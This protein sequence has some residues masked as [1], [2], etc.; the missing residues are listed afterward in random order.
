[1]V[2]KLTDINRLMD[3][4]RTNLPGSLDGPIQLEFF[5]VLNDF[6][7]KSNLWV[8]DITFP[9][10]ASNVQ[11]STVGIASGDGGAINR[12]MYV[13][14]ADNSHRRMTM[15][16]PGALLFV[17]VPNAAATWT[18]RVSL[19]VIDPIPETG[20]L[21]GFPQAPDWILRKYNNGLLSGLLG[22]MMAQVAKPYTNP[23]LALMHMR[24][25]SQ[26]L[27]NARSEARHQNLYA[28]QTWRFPVGFAT[29][30][31]GPNRG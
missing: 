30:S 13:L 20:R 7:Q 31:F 29:N 16:E 23:K 2:M 24:K 9:V 15:P 25:Y 21:A 5:N 18:A 3:N 22:N 8:E 17:D 26:A 28:V 11:G 27:A 19:T 14:D 6:F 12:L 4:A 1:M 10:G